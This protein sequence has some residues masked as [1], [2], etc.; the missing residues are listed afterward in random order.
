MAPFNVNYRCVKS[1]LRIICS[2]T[3]RST[4]PIHHAAF[5]PTWR[6]YRRAQPCSSRSPDDSAT[7]LDG[8]T[9]PRAGSSPTPNPIQFWCTT[10]PDDLYIVYTGGTTGMPK[11]VLWRQNYLHGTVRRPRIAVQRGEAVTRSRRSPNAPGG[12]V[13]TC[14]QVLPPIHAVRLKGRA[15]RQHIRQTLVFSD[16]PGTL[17]PVCIAATIEKEQP[18][19]LMV[20]GDAIARPLL[21][22]FE[23]GERD[24]SPD[25][26]LA[27]RR[28]GAVVPQIKGAGVGF[29]LMARSSA[30]GTGSSETGAMTHRK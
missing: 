23:K 27:E 18:I 10:I 8:A 21:T 3:L 22:E 29:A 26:D 11:G 25:Q 14:V 15:H 5:A 9:R 30:D 17:D 24:V 19:A 12:G 28:R 20:V 7:L 1:E 13:S 16:V 2:T 6:T 4:A